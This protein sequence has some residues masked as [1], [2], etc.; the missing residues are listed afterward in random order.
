L[1]MIYVYTYK[2]DLYIHRNPEKSVITLTKTNK[3]TFW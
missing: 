2:T 3:Q 1:L